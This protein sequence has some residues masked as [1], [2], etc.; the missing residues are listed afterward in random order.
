MTAG[1]QQARD[2]T[3]FPGIPRDLKRKNGI[4]G[5]RTGKPRPRH[6][7]RGAEEKQR[8]NDC[9]F[10]S[11]G[12]G[13]DARRQSRE[14]KN[15][16]AGILQVTAEADHRQS[17]DQS[18]ASRYAVANRKDDD[19]GDN[20]GYGERLRKRSYMRESASQMLVDQ[21]NGQG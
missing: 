21:G 8:S 2:L 4:E 12:A 9:N 17:A 18:D 16:I 15:Q 5:L 14:S 13:R 7:E 10:K 6:Q 19:R 1:L 11:V 3:G 20:P